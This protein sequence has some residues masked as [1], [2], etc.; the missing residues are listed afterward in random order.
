MIKYESDKIMSTLNKLAEIFDIIRLVNPEICREL[1]VDKDG[2]ISYGEN[3]Y[4]DL[5]LCSQCE[6]CSCLSALK[7]KERR[8]KYELY[9]QKIYS[10]LFIPIVL[11]LPKNIEYPCVIEIVTILSQN[12][13]LKELGDTKEIHSIIADHEGV[14]LDS[15]TSAFSRKFFEEKQYLR[16]YSQP[17]REMAFLF[18]DLNNFKSIND[19]YGHLAGDYVLKRM[20]ALT[21]S[22]IGSKDIIVR[23]GGDEFLI[24]LPDSSQTSAEQVAREI[25]RKLRTEECLQDAK[26]RHAGISIGIAHTTH[27]HSSDECIQKMLKEADLN[28]YTD[29]KSLF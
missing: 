11:I 14:Y 12:Q 1:F 22:V 28:M 19:T 5:N 24:I 23:M 10:F 25:K 17:P 4:K 20:V 21:K 7:A 8:E 27:F 6:N 16:N 15:L 13:W 3:C 2:G 26:G 29:K 18:A 9:N